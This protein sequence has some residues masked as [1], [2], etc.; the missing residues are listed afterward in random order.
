[1]CNYRSQEGDTLTS[2]DTRTLTHKELREVYSYLVNNSKGF[3]M[4]YSHEFVEYNGWGKYVP[5]EN[6]DLE[7]FRSILVLEAQTLR[8]IKRNNNIIVVLDS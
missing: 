2:L 4:K 5:K 6:I 7:D 1:M 3:L 8:V